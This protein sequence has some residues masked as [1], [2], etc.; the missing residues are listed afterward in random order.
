MNSPST[1]HTE[2]LLLR[3]WRDE[4]REPFAAMCADP[5]VMEFFPKTLTRE[6]CDQRVD[7]IMADFRNRGWGL[8]AVEAPG[9]LPFAGFIGLNIVKFDAAFT[10]AVEIGWR[11]ARSAWGRGT[12]RKAPA[13]R[14]NMDFASSNWRKSSPT[15]RWPTC[16]HAALWIAWA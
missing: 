14:S 3:P 6:E 12:Q 5:Q 11:L 16:A 13:R 15:R 8:W 1:L 9:V 4:D 10:P 7:N 2:R